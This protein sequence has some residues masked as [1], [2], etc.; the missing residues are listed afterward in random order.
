MCYFVD[1]AGSDSRFQLEAFLAYWLSYFVFSGPP[2]DGVHSSMFPMAVM[3]AQG[4]KFALAPWFLGS[5]YAQLDECSR[6]VTWSIGRNDAVSY[7]EA[8]FLQLFLRERFKGLVPE[9]RVFKAP[10]PQIVDGVER[11]K[12]SYLASWARRWYGS[13]REEKIS[14]V[15]LIDE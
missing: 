6:N 12:T 1:G 5:L 10:Q 11:V 7:I 2:E 3:L 15:L 9:A 14:P 13:S 8:N 4:R